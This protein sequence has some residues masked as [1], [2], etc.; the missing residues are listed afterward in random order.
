[1]RRLRPADHNIA[2]NYRMAKAACF[3][4]IIAEREGTV[5]EQTLD[6]L[7]TA[8]APYWADLAKEASKRLNRNVGAPSKASMDATIGKLRADYLPVMRVPDD[9]WAGIPGPDERQLRYQETV[10]RLHDEKRA[11]DA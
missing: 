4:E 9:P 8:G 7:E 5:T 6:Y 10:R 11:L 2:E 1:M 3:A